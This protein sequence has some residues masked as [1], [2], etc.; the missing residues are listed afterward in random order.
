MSKII[1]FFTGLPLKSDHK[2]YQERFQACYD[3]KLEMGKC[4][5]HICREKKRI[6][7]KM[8]K[9]GRQQMVEFMKKE[10]ERMYYSDLLEIFIISARTVEKY[11]H[12]KGKDGKI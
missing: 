5:C 4:D 2:S 8:L 7:A 10:E 9:Y 11:L 6:A 3:R 12:K 1:D